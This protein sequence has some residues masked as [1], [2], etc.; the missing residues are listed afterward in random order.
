MAVDDVPTPSKMTLAVVYIHGITARRQQPFT[1]LN[2]EVRGGG[3]V[4]ADDAWFDLAQQIQDK[5]LD[6]WKF[7]VNK[8]GDRRPHT[9]SIVVPLGGCVRG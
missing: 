8:Q 5:G 7:R 9:G 3:D 1:I 2:G 4:D 6:A